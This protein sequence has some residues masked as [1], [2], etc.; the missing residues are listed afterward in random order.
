MPQPQ[1]R[2]CDTDRAGVQPIACRLSFHET[3]TCN[4]TAI[5]AA[6][7]CHIVISTPVIHVITWIS[8]H[9]PTPGG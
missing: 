4:Q 9:L 6:L 5:Y 7:V 1:R 2:F 8:T 3:F